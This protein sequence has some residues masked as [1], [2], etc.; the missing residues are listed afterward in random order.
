MCAYKDSWGLVPSRPSQREHDRAEAFYRDLMGG[1]VVLRGRRQGGYTIETAPP[2]A[3]TPIEIPAGFRMGVWMDVGGQSMVANGSRHAALLHELGFSEV[4]IM[5]NDVSSTRFSLG[6]VSERALASFVPLLANSGIRVTL[7][8]WLRPDKAYIDALVRTL[9]PLAVSTGAHAIEIDAESNWR[10]TPVGPSTGFSSRDEATEYFYRTLRQATGRLEIAITCEVDPMPSAGMAPLLRGADIVVPQAYS[11]SG[12]AASHGI[13]A[14]YGPRGIQRRALD[15]HTRAMDA[16]GRPMLMGLAGYGR[17]PW[18]GNTP[19]AVMRMELEEALALR[20]RGNIRGVRYWSWKH[21]AG[22]DGRGGTP[23]NNYAAN[24]F[25]NSVRTPGQA[26]A[27]PTEAIVPVEENSFSF[28]HETGE[29]SS[30]ETDESHEHDEANPPPSPAP[31][32]TAA[33]APTTAQPGA[34]P[35][36][37]VLQSVRV[38]LPVTRQRIQAAKVYDPHTND[39]TLRAVDRNGAPVDLPVKIQ[40]ETRAHL[41]RYRQIHPVLARRVE[42]SGPGDR[43]PI[44]AWIFH[45][46]EL[47]RKDT[48]SPSSTLL[49]SREEEAT[50]LGA[51]SSGRLE[52]PSSPHIDAL[53]ASVRTVLDAAR[54]RFRNA[55]VDVTADLDIVPV[56]VAE[57]TKVQIEALSR[58]P[59]VTGLYLHEPDG[60]EDLSSSIADAKAAVPHGRGFKGA[61]I[62]VGVWESTPNNTTDLVIEETF[63]TSAT[64]VKSDHAQLV[65]AVIKNKQASGPKGFAPDCKIYSANKKSLAALVWA[66]QTKRCTV[67]NQSFHRDSEQTDP[68]LSADDLIADYLV[69]QPPYPTI[70]QAAGNGP[71]TEYVNHKGFNT[72]R[73]GN[74]I[75]G[76]TAMRPTSVF[77]DPN[78]THGDRE[79]PDLSAN[80]TTVTATGVTDSGTSFASPAVAGTV[81]VLQSV[82]STLTRWPVACRAI[83]LASCGRNISGGTWSQAAR[84]ASEDGIDG[85]GA[86]DAEEAVQIARARAYRQGA[87]SQ[88]GWDIGYLESMDLGTNGVTTFRWPVQIPASGRHTLK[89]ALAWNSK[90]T[91]TTDTTLTPPV[92]VTESKLTVDLDLWIYRDNVLVAHSSTFDSSFEIVEFEAV[93]GATY[94]IRIKRF[95]G[96]DSAEYGIGWTVQPIPAAPASP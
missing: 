50:N 5:L 27:W 85:S 29:W 86:L 7:T 10:S 46:H 36:T 74:H 53:R 8:S 19:N 91:Y 9:P 55:G 43:I 6:M 78:S 56:L 76:A 72:T 62:R 28:A 84:S 26:A 88:R 2:P 35:Q 73:V 54:A 69:L 79:L 21:I 12:A 37:R 13:G 95:S 3:P 22:L 93:A 14:P 24:F 15:L 67:L 11:T 64:A 80:G 4:C 31:A 52:P 83:L 89:A 23:A 81:A 20:T 30:H 96:T 47:P 70:V 1:P 63:D 39:T 34:R 82:D 42:R 17:D 44:L 68:N 58:I 41:Q 59:E 61:N 57:A 71:A 60:F 32:S 92:K 94:E 45:E 25:R 65:T 75:D 49:A 87:A 66:I 51:S 33:P 38:D 18:P 90:V 40:A 16:S 77:R 48:G